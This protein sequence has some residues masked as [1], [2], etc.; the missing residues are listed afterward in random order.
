VGGLSEIIIGRQ[1][2]G[3]VEIQYYTAIQHRKSVDAGQGIVLKI[4]I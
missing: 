2:R 4:S 3:S 1:G